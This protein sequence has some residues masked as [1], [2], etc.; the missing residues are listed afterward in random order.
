MGVAGLDQ[1]P[2][3]GDLSEVGG[4]QEKSDEQAL[5][6]DAAYAPATRG[7]Q[8]LMRSVFD[9]SVHTLDGVAVGGVGPGPLRGTEG[10]ILAMPRPDV[11]GDGDGGLGADL[12]GVCWCEQ[13]RDLAHGPLR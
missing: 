11:R 9:V 1:I 3:G 13:D 10:Q 8:G 2:V 7:R 12:W 5:G 4:H 6:G